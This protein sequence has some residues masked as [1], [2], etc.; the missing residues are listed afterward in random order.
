[1]VAEE[2]EPSPAPRS[3][4]LSVDTA[5]FSDSVRT[6]QPTRA[7]SSTVPAFRDEPGAGAA[8]DELD[9]KERVRLKTEAFEAELI[10][11]A[12]NKTRWN[13][14]EAAKVLR[15]PLR[16]LARK[17]KNYRINEKVSPT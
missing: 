10:I 13:Q 7:L 12:L 16:T 1:M 6:R 15:I 4:L 5:T 3:E 9:F 14:K 2:S 17:I 11:D 8:D